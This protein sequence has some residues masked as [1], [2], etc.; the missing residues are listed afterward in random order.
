MDFKRALAFFNVWVNIIVFV[1][2]VDLINIL[3]IK[4]LLNN[5]LD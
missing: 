4:R 1:Y 5:I 3:I 2:T